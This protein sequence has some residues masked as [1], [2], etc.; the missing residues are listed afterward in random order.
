[1]ISTEF[2]RNQYEHSENL[3]VFIRHGEKSSDSQFFGS[4]L[5]SKKG[6]SDSIIFGEKLKSLEIPIRVF[7]SPEF[8]CIQ[9]SK[10]ISKS[11]NNTDIIL[12]KVLGEPGIQIRNVEK[13]N[14]V[15]EE[16]KCREIFTEWKKGNYYDI[17]L[18]PDE[19][20]NNLKKFLET[21]HDFKG[22][23]VCVTQSGTVAH[24]GHVLGTKSYNVENSEWV[25][26]LDGFCIGIGDRI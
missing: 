12:T 4:T 10:L 18:S 2:I 21:Y 22:I 24:I 9:T 14:K 15:Y 13:Y 1:M 23:T 11:F 20:R 25:D 6:E 17:L 7:S 19:L 5:L 16:K 3:F 26:F 8:R